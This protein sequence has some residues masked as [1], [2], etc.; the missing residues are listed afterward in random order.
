[1]SE[2]ESSF[3]ESALFRGHS[4]WR[5][6]EVAVL[7]IVKIIKRE[8][9]QRECCVVKTICEHTNSGEELGNWKREAS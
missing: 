2:S 3:L 4:W 7:R 6:I 5:R 1:M 9:T 8:E